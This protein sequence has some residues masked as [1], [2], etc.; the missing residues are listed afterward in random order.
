MRYGGFRVD[1]VPTL[2]VVSMAC[3]TSQSVPRDTEHTP[4][5]SSPTRLE[6]LPEG[7][8]NK[9]PGSAT[10][11]LWSKA[12]VNA[13]RTIW[14]VI[15]ACAWCLRV[16]VRGRGLATATACE[17]VM[18]RCGE[19]VRACASLPF[20]GRAATVRLSTLVQ[21]FAVLYDA[22]RGEIATMA[23]P[24]FRRV[25][26]GLQRAAESCGSRALRCREDIVSSD[27]RVSR[28]ALVCVDTLGPAP[29]VKQKSSCG[30]HRCTHTRASKAST[31]HNPLESLRLQKSRRRAAKS[32]IRK[33]TR[34]ASR[35]AAPQRR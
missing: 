21:T 13:S 16:S 17:G 28:G 3:D 19:G 1:G 12:F 35:S 25:G 8:S 31:A 18:L 20:V 24:K 14:F 26:S 33:A 32:K 10:I 5:F 29:A 15:L 2:A 34:S 11:H 7:P 4:I 27:G 22:R 23:P 9:P 30:A 6:C